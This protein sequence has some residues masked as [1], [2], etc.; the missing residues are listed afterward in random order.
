MVQ[1]QLERNKEVVRRLFMECFS[2]AHFELLDDL[3]SPD[4]EFEYPN[5]P[6]GIEGLKAIV[7][8]NNE[9]FENWQPK[10]HELL[11]E[12]DKVVAR[13]SCTGIHTKS[14]LGE[15]PTGKEVKLKGIAIYTLKD[16][17]VCNDWV[18]SDNLGFLTQLGALPTTDFTPDKQ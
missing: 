16:G 1:D 4:F 7:K 14:F 10:V 8:K 9:T 11:A 5:V 17:K 18:E 3:L 6:P 15:A 12:D 2:G 13:W